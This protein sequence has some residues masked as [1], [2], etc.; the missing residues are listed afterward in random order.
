MLL[1]G[2]SCGKIY[3][4]SEVLHWEGSAANQK[5]YQNEIS[6]EFRIFL[7]ASRCFT[8]SCHRSVVTL[9]KIWNLYWMF[10][11]VLENSIEIP[12]FLLEDSGSFWKHVLGVLG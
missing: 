4:L 6:S 2:E 12:Y 7:G 5:C 3:S 11:N 1:I 10:L 9:F 8:L